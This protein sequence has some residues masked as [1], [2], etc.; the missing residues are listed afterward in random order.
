[1]RA[2]WAD[3]SESASLE[4]AR[5]GAIF[6]SMAVFRKS[7]VQPAGHQKAA[8]HL[9]VLRGADSPDALKGFGARVRL[10]VAHYFDSSPRRW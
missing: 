4:S 8:L 10:P 7:V 6:P 1:M 3:C 5:L 9:D 2:P